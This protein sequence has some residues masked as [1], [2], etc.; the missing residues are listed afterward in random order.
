MKILIPLLV[1]MLPLIGQAQQDH[2]CQGGHN[3]NDDGG[4]VVVDV[5][6]G[7][8]S[9]G[10]DDVVALSVG[11]LGASAVQGRCRV[12]KQFALFIIFKTQG[13]ALDEWCAAQDMDRAGKHEEAAILRCSLD[14]FTEK[15]GVDDCVDRM[16]FGPTLPPPNLGE[17]YSQAAKDIEEQYVEEKQVIEERYTEQQTVI[18]YQVQKLEKQ[19]DVIAQLLRADT[20]RRTKEAATKAYFRA[21]YEKETADETQ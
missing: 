9:V 4:D 3:C 7:G 15:Y 17:I 19:D 14:G 12:T 1:L 16:N 2:G 8:T 6:T 21:K 5:V 18:D 10:G 13:S 20:E 11:S